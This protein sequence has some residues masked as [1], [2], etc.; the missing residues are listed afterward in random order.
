MDG[1]GPSDCSKAC[2]KLH[3]LYTALF[4]SKPGKGP[5]RGLEFPWEF[6]ISSHQGKI[7]IRACF[8][9]SYI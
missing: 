3:L 8:A 4:R 5:G 1:V 6:W 7:K 2:R 9:A